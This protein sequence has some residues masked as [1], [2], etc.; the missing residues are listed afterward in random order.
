MIEHA[1]DDYLVSYLAPAAPTIFP[2][3][4]WTKMGESLI[5]VGIL[6]CM[7]TVLGDAYEEFLVIH[8]GGQQG[9]RPP[10]RHPASD[11]S[12]VECRLDPLH[13]DG[14]GMGGLKQL[15]EPDR[16]AEP[17]VLSAAENR[18]H[19]KAAYTFC[20]GRPGALLM[21]LRMVLEPLKSYL[22]EQ[23]AE[24]GQVY[25]T[26][27]SDKQTHVSGALPRGAAGLLFGR[28][29][30]LL[31][32]AKGDRDQQTMGEIE[33][34]HCVGNFASFHAAVQNVKYR[35]LVFRVLS[36][37]AATFYQYVVVRHRVFPYPLC[38][39]PLEPELKD[40]ILERCDSSY[41]AYT[42]SFMKDFGED[43][44]SEAALLELTVL[45]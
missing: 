22:Y 34:L 5:H 1:I 11:P 17:Q 14:S 31:K 45:V 24:S 41:D 10:R 39:L 2:R 3:H 6:S 25:E 12:A 9:A 13:A 16:C 7:N 37:A 21:L 44:C 42:E 43:I 18:Y 28:E 27:Q 19:R 4:R 20:Y 8:H 40:Q 35:H 33:R 15:D 36:R 26:V 29:W 30:P 23:L 38:R 32:A